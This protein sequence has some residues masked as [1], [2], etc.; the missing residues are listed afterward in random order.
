MFYSKNSVIDSGKVRREVFEN[1]GG[2]RWGN[3]G[4]I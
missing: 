1:S 4:S 3:E 2:Q